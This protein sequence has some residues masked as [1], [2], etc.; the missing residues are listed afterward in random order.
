MRLPDSLATAS[1]VEFEGIGGWRS[2]DYTAGDYAGHYA[3]SSDRLSYFDTVNESRG[4]SEF[5]LAGPEVPEAIEGRCRMRESSLD[6]GLVELTTRP[7]AYRCEFRAGNRPI[8]ASLELQEFNGPGAAATRYERRGRLVLDGET[9]DIRSV[10]H[11]AGTSMPVLTPIGYVF[12][13]R[14]RPVGAVE[15]NGRPALMI[16]PGASPALQRTLTLAAHALG[17]FWDPAN[18]A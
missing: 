12:E 18:T 16:E 8:A 7:M 15:L 17:V 14:G 6:L 2:G 9:I 11:I 4:H 10:H 3:R 5:T 1:R 13:Q